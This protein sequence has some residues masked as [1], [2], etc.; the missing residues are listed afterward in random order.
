MTVKELIE[1]LKQYPEDMKVIV[2]SERHYSG[3]G[4]ADIDNEGVESVYVKS[5]RGYYVLCDPD[6]G[7]K[8]VSIYEDISGQQP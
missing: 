2:D 1:K 8:A 6:D 7:F 5:D 3:I 4:Y